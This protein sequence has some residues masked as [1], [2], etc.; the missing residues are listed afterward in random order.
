MYT[1]TAMLEGNW[2]KIYK[3]G[4]CEVGDMK[5]RCYGC[6]NSLCG[7]QNLPLTDLLEVDCEGDDCT[8]LMSVC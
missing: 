4:C 5:A 8:L 1:H 2:G 6:Q 3:G 7:C